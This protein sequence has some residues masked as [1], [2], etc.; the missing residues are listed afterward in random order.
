MSTASR[1]TSPPQANLE[2]TLVNGE[3]MSQPEFH[4][5]YQAYPK[6]EKWELIGG[7]VYMTSPMRWP[8]G[9]YDVVLG[10]AIGLYE[11]AT[12]GVEG[13]HNATSI[14]GEESEPQPDLALRILPQYG[15]RSTLNARHYVV[16]PPEFVAEIAHS[17]RDL[18]LHKKRDDYQQAGVVEYL[19]LCVEEQELRWTYFPTGRSIRANRQGVYRSHIFPGLWLNGSALMACNIRGLMETLQQGLSS[20]EHALFVKRLETTFH[21]HSS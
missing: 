2:R 11:A 14:L 20:P 10:T 15:G 21:R 9:H 13:A 12:P 19:V 4:R 17:S 16:G 1:R 3:R 6:E 5:R 8:H 18:D 7:I